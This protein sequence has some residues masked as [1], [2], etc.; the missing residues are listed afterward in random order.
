ML[1]T[2]VCTLKLKVETYIY[3]NLK[4][5]CKQCICVETTIVMEMSKNLG[6]PRIYN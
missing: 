5:C 4:S 3:L 1:L 2:G 6:L